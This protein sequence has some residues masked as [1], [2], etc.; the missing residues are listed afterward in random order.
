MN[1]RP[2]KNSVIMR[3][4]YGQKTATI[5]RELKGNYSPLS[6]EHRPNSIT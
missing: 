2:N 6:H 1:Y 5:E 3:N 4:K